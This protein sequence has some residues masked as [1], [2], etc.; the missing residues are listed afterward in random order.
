MRARRALDSVGVVVTADCNLRCSYCYENRKQPASV[1]WFALATAI[2]AYALG[3]RRR[4]VLSFLGG[5]PLLEFPL[6]ARAVRRLGRRFPNRR[7]RYGLTTNGLLLT[8]RRIAFLERHRFDVQISCD[9]VQAAQDLRARGTFASLDGLLDRM[10]SRHRAFFRRRVT[11]AS[12]ATARTIPFLADSFDYLLSK[13]PAG[14]AIG[15]AMGHR[16]LTAAETAELERQ[17]GRIFDRSR[18][19]YRATGRVPLKLL[20]KTSPD[21]KTWADGEWACAAASGNNLVVDVDGGLYPCALL[22]RSS[23]AVARPRLAARLA[24]MSLGNVSDLGVVAQRLGRLPDAARSA[25]IFRPQRLKRSRHGRC[26]TC[27]HAGACFVCPIACAKNP[28]SARTDRIPDFQ[29]AFNRIVLDYRR[30]F[31]IQPRT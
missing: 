28:D 15:P 29:C 16:R 17:F 12:T 1:P 22:I 5:E 30:R 25:G 10:R 4:A 26:A 3:A 24:E 9:G 11:L 21:P 13:G 7:P 19:H 31:P 20:R 23:Q 27:R 6:I 2:D 18:E 8:G 14:I